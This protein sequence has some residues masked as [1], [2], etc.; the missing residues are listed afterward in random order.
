MLDWSV[1]ITPSTPTVSDDLPP[2]E[3]IRMW[4]PI[5]STLIY[6]DR[7]AILV[8]TPTTVAQAHALADWVEQSGKNLVKIYVTHGHGDHFFGNGAV[9]E[10]FPGA[11]VIATPKVVEMMRKQLAPPVMEGLWNKR[12]PGLIPE[13]IELPEPFTGDSFTLEGEDVIIIDTGHTDM[14]CTTSL[15]VPCL[16]LLVA[17]DLAYNGVHQ[18]FAES[19]THDKRMQWVTALEKVSQLRLENVVAGHRN[20]SLADDPGIIEQTRHYILSFDDLTGKTSSAI[21][22]YQE[23]LNRFPDHLNKGA[24]WGSARAVKG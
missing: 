14:D 2:G 18:Y 3:T 8:D 15:H 5:S 21:E 1:F 9:L 24:L 12:F 13:V 20:P 4:S 10:R 19:E 11:D 17:G 7:D 23:M 16:G 22:L 6:G